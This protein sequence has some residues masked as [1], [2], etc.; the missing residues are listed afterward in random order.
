MNS[1][2]KNFVSIIPLTIPQIVE[3]IGEKKRTES[4]I[5]NILTADICECHGKG[6]FSLLPAGTYH[7][8][9]H[10]Y[11]HCRICGKVTCI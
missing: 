9:E 5:R 6:A 8:H 10:R 3:E 4:D 11:I 7:D 1:I 2:S